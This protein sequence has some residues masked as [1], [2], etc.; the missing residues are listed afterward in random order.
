MNII[1]SNNSSV[2]IYEQI[3]N[4]IKAAI[5]SNEL[6]EEDMLPSVRNLANDLKISFLTVKK[7]YDELEREGF[8]KTVQGK[9]SFIAPKN[10]ELIKEEKLKEIQDYIEKIYNISKVANIA[11]DEIKELFKMIFEED[12]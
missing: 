7:A 4:A 12:F 3:N 8:I 11:E 5:F 6:K 2:P 9:G 1:I 10:L